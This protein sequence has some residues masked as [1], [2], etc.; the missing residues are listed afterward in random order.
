MNMLFHLAINDIEPNH[1]VAWVIE[2]HGCFS[3]GE[4]Y[5]DAIAF[6][7]DAI[8]NYFQWRHNHEP[9]FVIPDSQRETEI[10]EDIRSYAVDD[11][12]VNALFEYDKNP[13][14]END[15]AEIGKILSYTRKDLLE[16]IADLSENLMNQPIETEVTDS[17][18][19]VIKHIATAEIWYFDRIGLTCPKEHRP[20]RLIDLLHFSR[21]HTLENLPRLLNNVAVYEKRNELWTARKVMRRTLWHEIAHTRQIARYKRKFGML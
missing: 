8:H 20:E 7:S 12:F 18:A 9:T 6:A 2:W 15:L 21:H 19:G 14:N 3:K 5:K 13:L 4:T 17:I 16:E 1:W 10:T 11:Y